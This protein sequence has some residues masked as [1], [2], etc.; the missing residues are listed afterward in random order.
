MMLVNDG[1]S[2]LSSIEADYFDMVFAMVYSIPRVDSVD[3]G[4]RAKMGG[5]IIDRQCI[6]SNYIHVITRI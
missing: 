3:I 5:L 4:R 2:L 1:E 6:I